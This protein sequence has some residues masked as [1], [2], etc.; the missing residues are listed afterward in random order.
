MERFR[1]TGRLE[2]DVEADSVIRAG[3]CT[4]EETLQS[5][6]D[7]FSQAGVIVDPHTAVGLH[8]ARKL[9]EPDYP[10]ICLA[11]AHPAKFPDAIAKAIGREVT[12]P[13]LEAL[14]G[15]ETRLHVLP[16]TT[17]AVKAFIEEQLIGVSS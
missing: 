4:D 15:K 8:V 9:A 11:T 10:C 5:I 17:S 3:S 12:H 16:A 1:Q 14:K 6:R 2:L 7:T 13:R